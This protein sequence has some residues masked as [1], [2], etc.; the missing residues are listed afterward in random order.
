M[1]LFLQVYS[2]SLASYDLIAQVCISMGLYKY[3]Y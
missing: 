2:S 1:W 3:I